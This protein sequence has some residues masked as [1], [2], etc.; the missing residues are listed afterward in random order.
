MNVQL[1]FLLIVLTLVCLI[2]F[3]KDFMAPSV[4]LCLVY[5][6]VIF[7]SLFV[8]SAWEFHISFETFLVLSLGIVGMVG[9]T[10]LSKLIYAANKKKA[11][12][13]LEN[14]IKE[15]KIYN[16]TVLYMISAMIFLVSMFGIL[17]QAR[18]LLGS[19]GL[20]SL[21]YA[22]RMSS[23]AGTS[24]LPSIISNLIL[25]NYAI[26]YIA[27][28]ICINN[29]F[30]T[31]RFDKKIVL[32]VIFPTIIGLLQGARGNLIHYF[33]FG[34]TIFYYYY[35]ISKHKRHIDFKLMSKIFVALAIAVLMFYFLKTALGR[36]NQAKFLEYIGGLLCA[37]VKLLDVYIGEK[38]AP[39]AIWGLETFTNLIATIRR[40][41]GQ[42]GVRYGDYANYRLINGISFGNVYT[43]FRAY[44]ADFRMQ[45]VVVL[46][47][48]MGLITGLF[49]ERYRR[50]RCNS[51]I[52][53][54]LLIYAYLIKGLLTDF[55]LLSLGHMPNV[56]AQC[57]KL[58][59]NSMELDDSRAKT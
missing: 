49:Y 46:P 57:S 12:K 58:R 26:G 28:Y 7:L 5:V 23:L 47:A 2:I 6:I 18:A 14:E 42:S 56:I 34:V 4:I 44:Y 45:G 29:W 9:G 40:W 16:G 55:N 21:I 10:L 37:P 22:Y 54:A 53:M 59:L 17:N 48:I 1:L 32:L 39:S 19:G 38:H 24:N 15:I 36:Q 51:I 8:D 41:T 50:K 33:L 20:S 43:A 31:R 30:V 25:V 52:N 27:L 35:M 11:Y 3:N 13:F